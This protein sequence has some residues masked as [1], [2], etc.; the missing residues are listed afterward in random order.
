MKPKQKKTRT[1]VFD[2]FR[3]Q[4]VPQKTL[5]LKLFHKPITIEE[6]KKNK[7]TYF[8]EA[9]N[10][11]KKLQ[12]KD[13]DELS[14]KICNLG[15]DFFLIKLG[16]KKGVKV[17]DEDFIKQTVPN[18]PDVEI[19]INNS[20]DTQG[21][22]ISRNRQAFS[23]SFIVANLLEKNFGRILRDYDLA[24]YIHPILKKDEFWAIVKSYENRITQI[25]F[26]LIK[27]NLADISGALKDDLRT[28]MDS[29]NSHKTYLEINAARESCLENINRGNENLSSVV[30]Y[31]ASGAGSV[32]LKAK[33]IS[34]KMYANRDITKAIEVDSL[35]ISGDMGDVLERLK[36]IIDVEE[37]K[38]D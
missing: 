23:N 31:V 30:D 4:L 34:V 19:F 16:P 29:T 33:G 24:I 20:K 37:F 7:N 6:L 18:Y 12:R 22:A 26:E 32:C 5:Q 36:G 14:F 1:K 13:E 21:I 10:G 11:I 38:N 25:R 28:L 9:L 15:K 27:P 35:E 3:Y 17:Q 8:A 2:L